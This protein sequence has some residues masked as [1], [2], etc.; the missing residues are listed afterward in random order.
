MSTVEIPVAEMANTGAPVH[1]PTASSRLL[2][3]LLRLSRSSD[4]R[5]NSEATPGSLDGVIP[6]PVLRSLLA[7]LRLRDPNTVQHVRRTALFATGLARFLGW[8]GLPLR[9]LE[10]AALL[11]DIGK[12][13]VPDHV[14]FK[15]GPLNPAEQELFALQHHVGMDVLQAC[16]V[17][18]EVLD[19]INQSNPNYDNGV[20]NNTE[21]SQGSRILAIADAYDSLSNK[22]VYRSSV[23]PLELVS[24]ATL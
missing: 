15:P 22:Q 13:G 14:L 18:Q 2:L 6:K 3:D 24:M 17:H 12:I 10:I 9:K 11:H 1:Y 7:A 20:R 4:G 8:E 16:R 21:L 23:V 19:I 5:L